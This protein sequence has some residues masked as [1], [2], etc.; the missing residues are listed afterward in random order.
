AIRHVSGHH[1]VALVE[2]VS[3]AN[4]DRPSHVEDFV[5]KA[6]SALDLGVHLL[7]VDLFAP[8]PHDL[9]GMHGAVLRRLQQ[10]DQP[11]D[12]PADEPATL[13]SYAVGEVVEIYVEHVAFGAFLPDMALFLRPDRYI[14]V[15]LEPTYHV[16]YAGMPAFW[17]GI[18]ERG[19]GFE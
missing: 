13:A 9:S 11:F 1:L 16:A 4:K 17:R 3:P 18:L 7:L 12:V 10:S 6:V 19:A 5:V 8:G 15:P 2:I 14:S